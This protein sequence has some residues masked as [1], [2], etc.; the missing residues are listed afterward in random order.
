MLQATNQPFAFDESQLCPT[1]NVMDKWILAYTQSL[2]K[3]V[4]EEMKGTL[5]AAL[6]PRVWLE[7]AP[8]S[9]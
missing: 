2:I 4:H 8:Y 1:T 3:F 7:N 6:I 9:C 5:R